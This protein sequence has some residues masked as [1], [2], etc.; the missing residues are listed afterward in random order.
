MVIEGALVLG[1]VAEGGGVDDEA[2]SEAFLLD[3]VGLALFDLSC[4][5]VPLA[6]R[7]KE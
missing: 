7:G 2:V 3:L 6:L 5:L 1:G 4:A